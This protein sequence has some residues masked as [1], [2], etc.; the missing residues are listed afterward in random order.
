MADWVLALVTIVGGSLY[1]HAAAS[2]PIG[3][4]GD[5]VGPRV[6]P[7]MIGAGL[8]LAGAMLAV[9]T[10]RK[11]PAEAGTVRLAPN[12]KPYLVLAVLLAW[13]LLYYAAFEPV[14]YV[15]STFI[16]ATALMFYFNRNGKAW[17]L[18]YAAALTC[19]AYGVFAKLLGVVLPA[20]PGLPL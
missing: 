12:R 2:L 20:I 6:F 4:V 1:L 10:L 14:G 5:E 3:L 18:L 16:Y 7:E 15:P 13:T 19:V 8:L 17:N 11:R 9:E